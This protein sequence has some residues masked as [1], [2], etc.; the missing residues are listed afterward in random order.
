MGK[1]VLETDDGELALEVLEQTSVQG[2]NYILV[3]DAGEDEDGACYVMKD[4]S[5]ADA[6]EADYAFV[7]DDA[8]LEAV[9]KIFEALMDGEDTRLER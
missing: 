2:I 1:I 5:P 7:E 6:E 8:E 9:F 3:T 4:M